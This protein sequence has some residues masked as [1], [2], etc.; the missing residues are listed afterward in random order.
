MLS[1]FILKVFFDYDTMIIKN[2]I[3]ALKRVAE[4]LIE[5]LK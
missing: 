4:T 3:P 2:L 1:I 5:Y